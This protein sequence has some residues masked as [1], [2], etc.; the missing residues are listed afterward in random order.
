MPVINWRENPICPLR[1]NFFPKSKNSVQRIQSKFGFWKFREKLKRHYY[2]E[3][4]E[5]KLCRDKTL[6]KNNHKI[7]QKFSY[8]KGCRFD[9]ECLY[10]HLE[11]SSSSPQQEIKLQVTARTDGPKDEPAGN[12]TRWNQYVWMLK[13]WWKKI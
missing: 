8:K 10:K 9:S 2:K 3:K 11:K 7:L 1:H 4:C 12:R 6:Q 13:E 5:D